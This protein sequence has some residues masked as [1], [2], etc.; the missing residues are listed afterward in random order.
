[1]AQWT[2]DRW[3][4]TVHRVVTP[5]PELA[6]DSRRLSIAYFHQPNYDAVISCLPGPSG[7]GAAKYPPVTSGDHLSRKLQKSG[8]R[9]PA[10]ISKDGAVRG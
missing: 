3:T 2:N 1:M 7:N 6:G 9:Q 4:S 10:S 8:S 5:P